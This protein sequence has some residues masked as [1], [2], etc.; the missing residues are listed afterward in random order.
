[1]Y[2]FILI[3]FTS[4][5]V[6]T[7]FFLNSI[8][9][10]VEIIPYQERFYELMNQDVEISRPWYL[11]LVNHE[12]PIPLDYEVELYS[13]DN[14]KQIDIRIK[15][16]YLA[17]IESAIA[18]GHKPF[19]RESYRSFQDQVDMMD[20]FI[21]DYK[22]MGYTEE[23]AISKAQSFVAIPGHSE[24]Q[25]GLAIDIN[26]QDHNNTNLFN[27]LEANAHKYGFVK[28]YAA[29]KKDITKINNEPWHF[30]YVSR[31]DATLMYEY[32][33]C[34]EE[35]INYLD[36]LKAYDLYLIDYCLDLYYNYSE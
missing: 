18:L 5:T 34:L 19:A 25:L 20:F 10:E 14:G 27:Y 22:G 1:M 16:E 8:K 33:L 23:K 21:N 35:Y 31:N 3:F 36:S 24:H 7:S 11:I 15:D 13:L 28:R 32:D 26:N 4:L 9:E 17:L 30:R 2:K 6:L 29:S 12:N